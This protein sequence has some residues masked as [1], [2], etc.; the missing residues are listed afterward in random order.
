MAWNKDKIVNLL[1]E[2]GRLAQRF[3]GQMHYELK[4]DRSI[5]TEADREIEDLFSGELERPRSGTYL[6]GEETVDRKGEAYIARAFEGETFVVD[7]ID[8]TAPYAH[9][10]PCWGISIGRMERGVLTDGAVYLPDM[11]ELVTSDGE[12]VL[13]GKL[14]GGSWTWRAFGE[15]K[16]PEGTYGL[17][18]ITQGVAKR[19]KVWLPNPVLVLGVAVLPMVGLLQG[20]FLAYLGT[21]K[22]WDVAGALPLLLRKGFSAT[23]VPGGE[24]RAVTARVEEAT[25]HLSPDS[26]VR[27]ALRTDLLVCHPED[28]AR[29]RNSF[30]C[31][32]EEEG[33]PGVAPERRDPK[34]T[35][36]DES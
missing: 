3:K 21:V 34:M 25:Y 36:E 28:E 4:A 19:G 33:N 30:T 9:L 26:K 5:V 31:G 27:W 12:S 14:A 15:R 23:V 18:S 8:G 11:G 20:R 6:I 22:L 32:D 2:A 24:R 7:P 35:T 10:L 13:E 1:L 29:L 16:R 17:F